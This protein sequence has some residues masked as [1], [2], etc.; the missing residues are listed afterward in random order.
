MT[1]FFYLFSFSLVKGFFPSFL[2]LIVVV[3][4]KKIVINLCDASQFYSDSCRRNSQSV[5]KT[6]KEKEQEKKSS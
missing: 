3:G 6:Q 4:G 2:N 5:H 1:F